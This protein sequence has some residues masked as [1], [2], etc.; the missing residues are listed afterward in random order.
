MQV[1]QLQRKK[2]L[3]KWE[4]KNWWILK[5]YTTMFS[6]NSCS[7]NSSTPDHT[8]QILSQLSP[9]HPTLCSHIQ[10]LKCQSLSCVTLF[11]TL[12]TVSMTGQDPFF[13]GFSGKE[14]WSEQP[15]PSPE[16][17]PDPGIKLGCPALQGDSFTSEP[18]ER[19]SLNVC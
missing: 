13:M 2:E 9:Q 1:K 4:L 10:K 19:C 11:V 12:S 17:L 16:D 15:I 8:G 6:T 14:Y 7:F 5:T 3:L 18:P